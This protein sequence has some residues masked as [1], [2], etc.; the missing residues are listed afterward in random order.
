METVFE[1][2]VYFRTAAKD[3]GCPNVDDL[4]DLAVWYWLHTKVNG[5]REELYQQ[6][7]EYFE[8]DR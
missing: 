7:L 1:G 3:K 5:T 2:F 8:I 4:G 6:A